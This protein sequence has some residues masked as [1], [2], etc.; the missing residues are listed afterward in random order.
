MAEPRLSLALSDYDHTRDLCAGIVPVEG[1]SLAIEILSVVEIFQRVMQSRPWD[2]H[3]MSMGMYVALLA[4][5]ASDL[6]AIPVFTSRMFRQ[7]AFFVGADSPL[8]SAADLRGGRVGTQ[9]WAMTAGIYARGWLQHGLGIAPADIAWVQAGLNAPGRVEHLRFHFP[10]GMRHRVRPETSLAALLAAGEIDA[11]LS[12]QA[13][14]G[15][16]RRLGLDLP[17][18]ERAYARASG[19][20]P[21]M[22]VIALRR[23]VAEAHPWLP[24]RLLDAF[25]IAKARS[26]A[27]LADSMVSR[28]PTP[29]AWQ[30]AEEARALFGTDPWPYG[31]AANRPTIEAFLGFCFEQ[32]V[33]ARRVAIEELFLPTALEPTGG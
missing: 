26:L 12:P 3:E 7:S 21:I 23:S 32:G 20:F 25:H 22:H 33:G 31:L 8:Q 14:Q 6:V 11:I 15:A 1:V 4:E 9:D 18:E 24:R 16:V 13:P 27:R 30:A 5:G 17:A 19:L 29:W 10:P 2:I 28:F